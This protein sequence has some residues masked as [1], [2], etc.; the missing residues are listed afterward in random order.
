MVEERREVSLHSKRP[1]EALKQSGR[2]VHLGATVDAARVVV[3]FA[4]IDPLVGITATP[5]IEA[6]HHSMRGER[7]ERPVDR[8]QRHWTR[9]FSLKPRLELFCGAVCAR[10]AQGLTNSKTLL[11]Y[12]KTDLTQSLF[13]GYPAGHAPPRSRVEGSVR[14]PRNSGRRSACPQRAHS[15]RVHPTTG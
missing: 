15:G 9:R 13:D 4:R 5:R 8:G 10:V 3:P 2:D 14:S 1:L 7:V 6:A 12:P 11:G